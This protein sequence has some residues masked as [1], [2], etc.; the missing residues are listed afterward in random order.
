MIAAAAR[1]QS[2]FARHM[3][4]TPVIAILRGVR[5]DEV[6]GPAEAIIAAGVTIIEVPL[7]SPGPFASISLLASHCGDRAII[8]GR[9]VLNPADVVRCRDA[10]ANSPRSMG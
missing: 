5:S 2:E 6:L 4:T 9:A 1:L 8:G 7:N 10:G 3:V